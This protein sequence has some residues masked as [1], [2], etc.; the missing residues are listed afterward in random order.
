MLEIEFRAWD[1]ENKVMFEVF[2]YDVNTVYPWQR[3]GDPEIPIAPDREDCILM[4]YIGIEDK[5]HTK[6]YVGDV[7]RCT[8]NLFNEYVLIGDIRFLP[9]AILHEDLISCEVI[10]NV[11]EKLKPY[12][13]DR[14]GDM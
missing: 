5:N 2:G 6:I 14:E 3:K 10:G 1:K 7:V 13:E 8:F 12:K 4:Q 11:Y 9:Q